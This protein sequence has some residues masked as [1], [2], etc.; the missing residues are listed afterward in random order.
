MFDFCY[1]SALN[2]QLIGFYMKSPFLPKDIS[3]QILET[4]TQ[5]RLQLSIMNTCKVGKIP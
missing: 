4:N 2:G 3:E 5:Q 1:H